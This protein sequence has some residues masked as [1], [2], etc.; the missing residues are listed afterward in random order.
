MPREILLSIGFSWFRFLM[1]TQA[2]MRLAISGVFKDDISSWY[3][4]K[5]NTFWENLNFFRK[6]CKVLFYEYQKILMP[7]GGFIDCSYL[8]Y[9]F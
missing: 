2:I 7:V 4:R 8:G 3:H 1:A 6:S 9:N 5:K